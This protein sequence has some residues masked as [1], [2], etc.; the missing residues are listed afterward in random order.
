MLGTMTALSITAGA[1]LSRVACVSE[2][3]SALVILII[4]ISLLRLPT[5]TVTVSDCD[6][7]SIVL[8][9]QISVYITNITHVFSCTSMHVGMHLI[10]SCPHI[11]SSLATRVYFLTHADCG[12]MLT[13]AIGEE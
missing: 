9:S 8:T 11:K 3:S 12:F 5:T 2:L 1:R 4:P 7:G 6:I 13:V 10:V